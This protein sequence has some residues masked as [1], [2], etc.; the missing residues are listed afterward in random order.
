MF[1]IGRLQRNIQQAVLGL[2]SWRQQLV[3]HTANSTYYEILGVSMNATQAD[4]K[5]AYYEK[6]KELHPDGKDC[7]NEHELRRRNDAFIELTAA[8]EV[9]KVPEQRR[10]Y[11]ISLDNRTFVDCIERSSF[12]G[13]FV[14]PQGKSTRKHMRPIE[15]YNEFWEKFGIFGY[16]LRFVAQSIIIA[17]TM[18]DVLE[19]RLARLENRLGMRKAGSV[20]NVNEELALLRKKLSEAGCGFLLKIPADVLHK[21]SHLATGSDYLTSTEK[22]REIEFGHDLMVE[23]VRLLEQFQKDSE[24]VFKSESIASVGHHIPALDIAEK[25]INDSALDVQKHHSS[26][27]D[28]KE[29]FV[30]ILEQL[31]YQILEWESTVENL[32]QE[33]RK[34]ETNA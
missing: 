7:S 27:V 29:K 12:D 16:C 18:E 2:G 30:I 3:Y 24:I 22:K 33:K 23:R 32:E 13:L 11:D 6:S 28:L 8:Y 10:A 34:K 4:I 20:T 19:K 31:N 14:N 17:V 5:K 1:F 21:I 9:L 25:E 26:V 15:M